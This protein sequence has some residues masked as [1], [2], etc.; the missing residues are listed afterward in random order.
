MKAVLLAA[1]EGLRL[2]PITATRPKHLIKVGGKPILQFCLEAVKHA[3]IKEA[4]IVTHYMGDAIRQ[5]FGDGEK[6]GLHISYVEQKAVLGTAD[7]AAVAEPYVEDDF[8]L[9]YGDLLF[10][11]DA[12]KNVLHSYEQKKTAAV[13]GVAPVHLQ[14]VRL[15]HESTIGLS[16]AQANP[17]CHRR[18][19]QPLSPRRR[20]PRDSVRLRGPSGCL[21]FPPSRR[22]FLGRAA[23]ARLTPSLRRRMWREQH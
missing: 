13:I 5:Y 21:G 3:G 20:L 19:L 14:V 15:H 2:L 9:V 22:T 4:I 8:V 23:V 7:A 11:P 1:G 18:D 6:L 17:E 12:V 10:G 16:P